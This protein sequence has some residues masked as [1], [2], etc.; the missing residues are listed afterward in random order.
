MEEEASEAWNVKEFDEDVVYENSPLYQYLQQIGHVDFESCPLASSTTHQVSEPMIS[1]PIGYWESFKIV[2]LKMKEK[3][4]GFYGNKSKHNLEQEVNC[5]YLIDYTNLLCA[6]NLLTPNDREYLE[7]YGTSLF[8]IN[9]TNTTNKKYIS[10]LPATIV[11]LACLVGISKQVDTESNPGILLVIL[12]LVS[13]LVLY[14]IT[15]TIRVAKQNRLKQLHTGNIDKLK[16]FLQQ[17]EMFINILKKSIR[18]VKESELI[19]R[20]FFMVTPKTP[21]TRLEHSRHQG[22]QRQCP[23]LRQVIFNSARNLILSL[24][25]ATC[26]LLEKFPLSSEVDNIGN[27]VCSIPLE[28]MGLCF[29]SSQKD[30]SRVDCDRAHSDDD[31]MRQATDDHSITALKRDSIQVSTC[32]NI[33]RFHSSIYL[34]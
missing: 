14:L 28:E 2:S 34:Y 7:T 1:Q 18:L 20:G 21:I 32:I 29:T 4:Y 30:T 17:S 5:E 16:S 26:T 27:Y 22:L 3:F 11:L 25:Q 23:A 8:N 15:Q 12:F 9:T 33:Q 6:S 19:A 24:R 13:L 31:V 10:I